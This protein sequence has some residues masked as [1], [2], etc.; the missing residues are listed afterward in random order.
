MHL[1]KTLANSLA[2]SPCSRFHQ[3]ILVHYA[4]H[5]ALAIA[6]L[7][8]SDGQYLAGCQS[9]LGNTTLTDVSKELN[10]DAPFRAVEQVSKSLGLESEATNQ[11][12]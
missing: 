9:G 10:K 6:R 11:H 4:Q 8:S 7:G 5:H 3:V 2:R 12:G 1:R